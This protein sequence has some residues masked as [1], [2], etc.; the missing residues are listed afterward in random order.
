[1]VKRLNRSCV[2]I[3]TTDLEGGAWAAP[4]HPQVWLY[5]NPGQIAIRLLAVW[6]KVTTK[7]LVVF[8][9]DILL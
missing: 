8:V 2:F 6:I 4:F 1:M 5:L 9:T 3:E 7:D